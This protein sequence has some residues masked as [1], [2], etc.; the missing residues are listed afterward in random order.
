MTLQ[1]NTHPSQVMSFSLNVV[2]IRDSLRGAVFLVRLHSK[3]TGAVGAGYADR[4]V[5]QGFNIQRMVSVSLYVGT[6]NIFLLA[7]EGWKPSFYELLCDNIEKEG[8]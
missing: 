7:A 5:F 8:R 6:G 1:K 3:L 4:D 2:Q